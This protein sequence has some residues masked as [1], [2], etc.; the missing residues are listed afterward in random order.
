MFSFREF[1]EPLTVRE[2][3]RREVRLEV[4][5]RVADEL[6]EPSAPPGMGFI[7]RPSAV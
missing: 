4:A 2:N 1:H 5:L 3:R 6:D 7:P